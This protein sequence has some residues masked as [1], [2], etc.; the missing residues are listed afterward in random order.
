MS[1]QVGEGKVRAKQQAQVA[2]VHCL[3]GAAP[4][5]QSAHSD[6]IR[7]SPFQPLLAAERVAHRCLQLLRQ[8]ND[9]VVSITAPVATED[10]DRAGGIDPLR[11][12]LQIAIAGPQQRWVV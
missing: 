3:V 2:I 4:A 11:Q 1:T 6:G 10:R 8:R 7:V 5:D 9:L 12:G